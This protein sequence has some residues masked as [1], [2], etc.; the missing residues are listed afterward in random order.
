MITIGEGTIIDPSAVIRGNVTIG[1]NCR[2][3]GC[4]IGGPAESYSVP[5]DFNDPIGSIQIGDNVVIKEFVTIQHSMYEKG[6]TFIGNNCFIMAHSHIGHDVI[7]EDNV[8]ISPHV[9]LGGHTHVLQCANVG[10]SAMTHQFST[11]GQCVMIGMGSIVVKD[12]PPFWTV[13]GNPAKF[14]RINKRGMERFGFSEEEIK[15]VQSPF[16]NPEE[17]KYL[18]L[19]ICHNHFNTLREPHRKVLSRG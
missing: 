11:V 7:L 19:H 16:F 5:M 17:T 10:I 13:I 15:E 4:Y 14:L 18:K 3:T 12:I 1:K 2:I 6:R 8:T 9:I